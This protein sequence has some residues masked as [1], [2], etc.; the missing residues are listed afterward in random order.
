MT[1][2]QS[3]PHVDERGQ[4]KRPDYGND[5]REGR[6]DTAVVCPQNVQ[7]DGSSNGILLL[8]D[9]LLESSGALPPRRTKQNQQIRPAAGGRAKAFHHDAQYP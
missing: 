9:D 5:A 2:S 1:E 3:R 6:T 7:I 4:K 8:R